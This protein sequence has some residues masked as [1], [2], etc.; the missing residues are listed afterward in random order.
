MTRFIVSTFLVLMLCFPGDVSC[1]I[2]DRIIAIVNDDIITLKEA[3]KYVQVETKGKY[4][5]VNEYLRNIQ[6]REKISTL[7]DGI[8]IKQ[9]AR[10]L[11]I[12]VSDRE[13]DNIVANIKKQYLIDLLFIL[14]PFS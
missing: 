11:K 6:L 4:V 13:I 9:Q 1:E 10:K 7:I 3:E 2:V 5:S 8:L 14:K 12:S